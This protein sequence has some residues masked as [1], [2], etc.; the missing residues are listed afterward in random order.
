MVELTLQSWNMMLLLLAMV[1]GTLSFSPS[2]SFLVPYVY[3]WQ[4]SM[5]ILS[6]FDQW[7]CMDKCQI[8]VSGVILFERMTLMLPAAMVAG[9]LCFPPHFWNCTIDYFWKCD[10]N[11]QSN[12]QNASGNK[13]LQGMIVIYALC[14]FTESSWF[15]CLVCEYYS[16][17]LLSYD[18]WQNCLDHH[19]LSTST[20]CLLV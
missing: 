3:H 12:K 20:T 2:I 8:Y 14:S 10:R 4:C 15:L 7:T 11:M 5:F 18:Y 13:L 17:A 6:W 16:N 19:L 1:G 9:T